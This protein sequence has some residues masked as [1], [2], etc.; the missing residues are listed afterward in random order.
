MHSSSEE[1]GFF[2][3]VLFRLR[4]ILFSFVK[5]ISWCIVL[6][7]TFLLRYVE[8]L[9]GQGEGERLSPRFITPGA[10]KLPGNQ[11]CTPNTDYQLNT[12][13]KFIFTHSKGM[14]ASGL[15]EHPEGP[16]CN[17]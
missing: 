8:N 11:P 10:K 5:I 13:P 6:L 4:W 17:L 16:S 9:I 2:C 14:Q 15:K 1:Y 12:W 7:R 3:S